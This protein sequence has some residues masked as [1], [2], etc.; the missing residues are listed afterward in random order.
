MVVTATCFATLESKDIFD[1]I[2]DEWNN[3]QITSSF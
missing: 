3:E 2:S 1:P